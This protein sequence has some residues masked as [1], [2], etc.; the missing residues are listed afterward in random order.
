M[1]TSL[2]FAVVGTMSFMAPCA[3]SQTV[4]PCLTEVDQSVQT[5]MLVGVGEGDSYPAAK[6]VALADALSFLG[7]QVKSSTSVTEGVRDEDTRLTQKIER[8]TEGMVKGAKILSYCETP[9]PK[10]IVG[11]PKATIAKLLGEQALQRQQLAERTL[12]GL[13]DD[14][15]ANTVASAA[16]AYEKMLKEEKEDLDTWLVIGK[17]RS[18]FSVITDNIKKG[19][20]EKLYTKDAAAKKVLAVVPGDDIAKKSV[21]LLIAKLSQQGYQAKL[22]DASDEG[23]KAAWNCLVNKGAPIGTAQRFTVRCVLTAPNFSFDPIS[24]NGIAHT[25]GLDEQ[26]L[27]LVSRALEKVP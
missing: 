2:I 15:S 12:K 21:P 26:A 20:E 17:S 27:V 10:V 8:D 3:Y 16:G 4:A 5:T 6:S 1:K 18:G 7:S 19:L 22:A 9:R 25:N 24:A 11:I 23:V 13:Q 14:S